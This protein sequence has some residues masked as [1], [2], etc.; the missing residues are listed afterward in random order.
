MLTPG[1]SSKRLRISA[2]TSSFERSERTKGASISELF[3]PRACS[4][5]SARPV[6]LAT[7]F[8][9]G[10]WRRIFSTL[11]PILSD[12]SRD[13]PGIVLTFIVNDPSLNGGKKLLPRLKKT[14]KARTS[15][16]PV[17]EITT[18]FLFIAF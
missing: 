17:M 14:T 4:S 11:P 2:I 1:I 13:I 5:S 7:V 12:S 18:L 8:I 9:S 16:A 6:F 10:I 3:T 15:N